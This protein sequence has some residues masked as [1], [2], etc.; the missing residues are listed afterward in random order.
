M[1]F[2]NKNGKV[3]DTLFILWAGLSALLSYSLVTA[4]RKPFTAATFDGY[5]IGNFDYKTIVTTVQIFGYVIAKFVGI[6]IIS[7]LEKKKRLRF[8][9]ISVIIAELSLVCFGFLPLPM[10]LIAM[11]INGLSLGCMWGVIF[12]FLE[13]RR[14]TDILA[15][16]MGLS[17]VIST[18]TIKSIALFVLNQL[19]INEFWMPAYIGAIAFSLII[20]TGFLLSRLPEPDAVDIE[21]KTERFTLQGKE[22]NAILK[23]FLPILFLLFVPNL[24]ITIL[25][26]IKE[27]FLTDI[28]DVTRYSDWVFAQVDVV[29][30]LIILFLFGMMVFFKNNFLALS[31]LMGGIIITSLGMV[32]LSVNYNYF[33]SNPV[34][35]LFLMSLGL[36]IPYLAYQTLFF[37]RFIACFQIRGNVG[38]FI[39]M[40]D[41][42]GYS[43]TVIVLIVKE[44]L[45]PNINWL[46]FYNA[47][48][49]WIGLICAISS[50]AAFVLIVIKHKKHSLKVSEQVIIPNEY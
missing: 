49:T 7:E 20:L 5:F 12:S 45:N 4:L 33:A 22:R 2:K 14:L 17:I 31:V 24:L 39:A 13:G 29:V 32:A 18:G 47:F 25:R 15:S 40:V 36:Y 11:F 16:L 50:L 8:I 27:D 44:F 46:T 23:Q 19:H 1:N 48:S 10:N 37:D 28:F 35:W 30:T 38:F 43:G 42:I 9:I 34:I 26:D 6:K 41:F 21:L 3:S